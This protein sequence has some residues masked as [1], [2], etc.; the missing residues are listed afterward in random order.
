MIFQKLA[1]LLALLATVEIIGILLTP[2]YEAELREAKATLR[3][4]EAENRM[5]TFLL[6]NK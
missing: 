6:D 5:L 3:Q 2:T 4:A 1:I